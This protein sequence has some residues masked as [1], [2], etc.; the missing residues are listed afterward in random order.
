MAETKYTGY[1][2]K[3]NPWPR[4]GVKKT[5]D[6]DS[7]KKEKH[8]D[9]RAADPPRTRYFRVVAHRGSEKVALTR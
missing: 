6:D 3:E 1:Q 5:G 4:R 8:R 9:N 7:G 2:R